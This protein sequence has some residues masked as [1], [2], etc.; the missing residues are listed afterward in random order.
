MSDAA[1]I[2]STTPPPP[3]GADV[4]DMLREV[5]ARLDRIESILRASR[6][7]GRYRIDTAAAEAEVMRL[8]AGGIEKWAAI[9]AAARPWMAHPNGTNNCCGVAFVSDERRHDQKGF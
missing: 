3:D 7:G 6:K 5:L 4:V 2:R 8:M 1:R 9:K